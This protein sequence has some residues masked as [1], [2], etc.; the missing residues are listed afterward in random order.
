MPLRRKNARVTAAGAPAGP[1]TLACPLCG[2]VVPVGE[3]GRCDLGH[4]VQPAHAESETTQPLDTAHD[5]E[6]SPPRERPP[7][8][9]VAPVAGPAAAGLALADEDGPDT[10][11]APDEDGGAAGPEDDADADADAGDTDFSGELDW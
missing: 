9:S 1:G 5:A 3:D 8:V 4:R 11:G 6:P 2:E 10:A 7:E